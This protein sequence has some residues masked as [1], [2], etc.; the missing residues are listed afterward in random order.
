MSDTV[1]GP[2]ALAGQGGSAAA[3]AGRRDPAAVILDGL[4]ERREGPRIEVQLPCTVFIGSHVHD[5]MLRDVSAG[6]G[7]VHGVRGMLAGDQVRLRL[8]RF[9]DHMF[10]AQVRGVS[11]LGVHLAVRAGAEQ[12]RWREAIGDLLPDDGAEAAR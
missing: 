9:A 8:A 6:G 5:G 11:L 12:A 10:Q 2:G 1:P 3:G 7:M 4:G